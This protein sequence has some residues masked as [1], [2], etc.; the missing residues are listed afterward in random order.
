MGKKFLLPMALATVSMAAYAQGDSMNTLSYRVKEKEIYYNLGMEFGTSKQDVSSVSSTLTGQNATD[1]TN[2]DSYETKKTRLMNDLTYGVSDTISIGLGLDLSL[3]NN[4]T[5][6]DESLGVSAHTGSI[7]AKSGTSTF[8]ANEIK[9][10][11]LEDLRLNSSYRYLT[12]DLKADL[13]VGLTFS[14]KSKEG[15]LI[16]NIA[17]TTYSSSSGDA[18]LGGSSLQLA[19]RF[20]SS[21]GGAFEWAAA[22]GLD[23]KMQKKV[24]VVGGDKNTSAI[25]D[26]EKVIQSNTDFNVNLAS[27]YNFSPL[28]SLGA[29]LNIKL[30]PQVTSTA[31]KYA[32]LATQN[33]S[34]MAIDESHSDFKLGINGKYQVMANVD[35]GLNYFHLM[36]GNIDGTEATGTAINTI[37]K[38]NRKDDLFGFNLAIRF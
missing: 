22:A 14:G 27:Q 17:D 12:G 20:A 29:S 19:T 16:T 31:T 13:L 1:N 3:A 4:T 7:S 30:V 32:G 36:G 10:N 23:Y 18:L 8:N 38:T 15:S 34:Y 5:I 28:F 9:N 11:G 37:S 25:I 24:T 2:H 35:L 6:T 33:V 26:F 21:F